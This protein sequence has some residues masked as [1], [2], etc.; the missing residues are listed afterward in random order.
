MHI[1]RSTYIPA[2]DSLIRSPYTSN[3]FPSAVVASTSIIIN[4]H[5]EITTLDHFIALLAH[6]DLYL[7]STSLHLPR[8]EAYKD[9]F[10]L[11][12]PKSRLEDLIKEEGEKAGLIYTGDRPP[13]SP[14][15]PAASEDNVNNPTDTPRPPPPPDIDVVPPSQNP[16]PPPPSPKSPF[17]PFSKS[18]Y[19]SL[20]KSKM[21]RS[22]AS[23]TPPSPVTPSSPTHNTARPLTKKPSRPD[24]IPFALL[25]VSFSPRT[26]G[27]VYTITSQTAGSFQGQ[28][29]GAL[30]MSITGPRDGGR[31]LK[32]TLVEISRPRDEKLEVAAK[33]IVECLWDVLLDDI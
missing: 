9:L 31:T 21:R 26:V 5:R 7:D 1:L 16:S 28:D 11:A 25:S 30:S 24:P 4:D 15:P 23:K 6:E 14:S 8:E 29:Y 3:P 19:I 20:A 10:D 13:P 27:L 2:Y 33:R 22:S 17:N 18:S 32:K 12:Q